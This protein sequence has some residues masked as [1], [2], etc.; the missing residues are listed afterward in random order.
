[1]PRKL[2]GFLLCVWG[3]LM[4][5]SFT[6]D[7]IHKLLPDKVNGWSISEQCRSYGRDNLYDYIDG[8]A[9]LY[10]SFGFNRLLSCRYSRPKQ[11]DIT[12]DI[13]DMGSPEHA[14]GVFSLGRETPDDSIGQESEYS[15][16]LLMFW[17]G[18]F[19]VSV[20]AYPE[21]PEAKKTVMDL[22]RQ[23]ADRI[24]ETG[25]IPLVVGLLP[26]QGLIKS[27]IRY[28][29]HHVWL[30]SHYFISNDNIL[31][32]G[33]STEAVMAGYMTNHHLHYLLL[34]VY[35]DKK[36]CLDAQSSFLNGFLTGHRDGIRQMEDLTWSGC[37]MDENR[38]W[39]VLHAGQPEVVL[40]TFR[41]VLKE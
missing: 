28:F 32:L 36:S 7:D 29:N 30:N 18:R 16:G 1:M 20:L 11:P 5:T 21:T 8:S 24:A 13:F 27:S 40:E 35:P 4:A 12:L 38:L 25:R 2:A 23:V 17:K 26:G 14:Y 3:C 39:I 34:V 15:G 19:Y 41:S 22:G 10:L 31:H 33:P 37:R 9:E 6:V